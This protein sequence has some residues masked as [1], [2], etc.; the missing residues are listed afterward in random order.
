MNSFKNT[1]NCRCYWNKSNKVCQCGLE[2]YWVLKGYKGDFTHLC[3]GQY[4]GKLNIE[5]N[6]LY[7]IMEENDYVHNYALLE[8]VKS[9]HF[10]LFYDIDIK[11]KDFKDIE[12][13]DDNKIN[14]I[15]KSTVKRIIKVLKKYIDSD[16]VKY[17]Y[18]DKNKGY[19]VHLYFPDIIVDRDYAK[20]L[21]G[22]MTLELE[23]KLDLPKNIIKKIIDCSVYGKN[24]GLRFLG[25]K[26]DN[27]FYKINF[28][29][30]TYEGIPIGTFEQ[31][32]LTR[33]T[34]EDKSMNFKPLKP[35]DIIKNDNK[36]N[37]DDID[38]DS[39]ID[40]N[41]LE[42]NRLLGLK[43]NNYRVVGF[44]KDKDDIRN[45]NNSYSIIDPSPLQHNEIYGLPIINRRDLDEG[46]NGLNQNINEIEDPNNINNDIND[47]EIE[48]PNNDS[49]NG[50]M[51][52]SDIDMTKD[53]IQTL[54]NLLKTERADDFE[55]WNLVGLCIHNIN[56]CYGDIFIEFSRRSSSYNEES[57]YKFWRSYSSKRGGLSIGTLIMW[58][59]EDNP[60]GLKQFMKGR[61]IKK[62]LMKYK[63]YFPKNE[64][65][66]GEIILNEDV[67][68]YITL[69]DKYCPIYEGEHN[70]NSNYLELNLFGLLMKC[71]DLACR[72]KT[73]PNTFV[74]CNKN[75]INSIF[76]VGNINIS[77][78]NS[79]NSSD[80]SEVM[81]DENIKVFE[82]LELNKLILKSINGTPYNIARCL[83]YLKKNDYN[84]TYSK[85]WYHYNNHKW[86]P[87][88]DTKIREYISTEFLQYYDKV[89]NHLNNNMLSVESAGQIKKIYKIIKSL[90]ITSMKNNIIMEACEIFYNSNELFED[91]LDKNPFLLGFTNGVYDLSKMEFRDGKPEDNITMN[92]GY[93]YL[94]K[95]TEMYPKLI[96]F[97]EDVLPIKKD[98]E[99]FLM[100]LSS[101]LMGRN[102]S[103][104]FTIATG[105]SGR[106][107]KSKMVELVDYTLGDYSGG[108]S[109][110]MFTRPRPNAE[111]ADPGLLNLINKR[112][113]TASEPEKNDK[114]NSGFIKLITGNDSIK[115]RKCHSNDMITFQANFKIMMICNQIPDI[116]N[117][118]KAFAKRLRC[119]N[120]PTEFTANPHLPHE[121]L[122]DEN[123]S[124]MLP[125]WKQDMMLLLLKYYPKFINGEL[126]PT[127]NILKW[128]DKYKEETDIYLSFL[129]ERTVVKEG[130]N[131]TMPHLF[132]EF[133]DWFNE[134]YPGD[135][136][137]QKKA[138][139]AGITQHKTIHT[140]IREN[141][142]RIPSR[143]IKNLVL[144]CD[145]DDNSE[146][147]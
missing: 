15:I 72:G 70:I 91:E 43:N 39:G 11:P 92:C 48:D 61:N 99:Y 104:L 76:N 6:T 44:D 101:C 30:S 64:L 75:Y 34:V 9:D 121:K 23:K 84:C 16:I 26:K 100:F 135:R 120:F 87:K 49:I 113:I 20:S 97:M 31:L 32:L 29:K 129:N 65:K 83:H 127:K 59:K 18:A 112:F 140:S 141:R 42:L 73:Y 24:K 85:N 67:Q 126:K 57:C 123:L 147:D 58:S 36:K 117:M 17:V 132:E 139:T 81:I 142:E 134:N 98:R 82:D 35:F 109:S 7:K 62:H 46:V 115:L 143:G 146:S 56:P 138:F 8:A 122:I 105:I 1:K 22:E 86:N 124:L 10:K 33:I 66:M 47:N 68:H 41:M 137:P 88:G 106:N 40:Y 28:D 80:E 12:G 114:F 60:E 94:D 25:Q 78:N 144:A 131:I 118:D 128:T 107:G 13:M 37:K 51:D 63:K 90:T 95:K 27:A 50:D 102:T 2:P 103:E 54:V 45:G 93:D 136:Y 71:S 38:D 110:S 4:S 3:Y 89:L 52:N 116:D 69:L 55:T 79:G 77:I 53:D 5:P 108:V 74:Q 125:L 130:R 133:K 111:S 19:G 14:K 145:L 96:K 119:I 21:V